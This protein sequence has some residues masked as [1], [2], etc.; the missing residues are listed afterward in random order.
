[1]D[2]TRH[3]RARRRADVDSNVERLGVIGFTQHAHAVLA[4][5]HHLGHRLGGHRLNA[6]DMFQRHDHQMT[7][8]VRIEIQNDKTM[9]AAMQDERFVIVIR[10]CQC[11]AKNT[12]VRFG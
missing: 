3:A 2:V 1:M 9:R 5:G 4:Q 12:A 7:V 8:V 6:L 10:S 11:V